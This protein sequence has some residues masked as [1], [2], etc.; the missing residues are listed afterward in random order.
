MLLDLYGPRRKAAGGGKKKNAKKEYSENKY[1]YKIN[2]RTH[3]NHVILKKL[4]KTWQNSRTK[5]SA[6]WK[7]LKLFSFPEKKERKWREKNV[8]RVIKLI[9][10]TFAYMMELIGKFVFRITVK[11][12]VI[13]KWY[14]W[15]KNAWYSKNVYSLLRSL[16]LSRGLLKGDVFTLTLLFHLKGDIYD[17]GIYISLV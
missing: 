8:L 12:K 1:I 9:S 4:N 16:P 7:K 17:Y 15:R 11:R 2:S 10:R 3:S 5:F 14:K 13:T 6:G